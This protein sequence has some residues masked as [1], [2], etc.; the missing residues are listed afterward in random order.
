LAR[1]ALL[2][3]PNLLWD[4]GM[5]V[6]VF[7]FL[8]MTLIYFSYSSISY[9]VVLAFIGD[10]FLSSPFVHHLEARVHNEHTPLIL[11]TGDIIMFSAFDHKL[12]AH[13]LREHDPSILWYRRRSSGICLHVYSQFDLVSLH[14]HVV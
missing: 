1:V 8:C 10:M 12:E 2:Q 3:V 9:K 14:I 7:I 11:L 6:L 5:S 13:V 4:L